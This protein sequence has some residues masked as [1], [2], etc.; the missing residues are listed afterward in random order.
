MAFLVFMSMLYGGDTTSAAE[1]SALVSNQLFN[2]AIRDKPMG[3]NLLSPLS[4]TACFSI[5]YPGAV[6]TTKS[7][8]ASSLRFTGMAS[9]FADFTA[10]AEDWSAKYSGAN[11]TR[12]DPPQPIVAVANSVWVD[13]TLTLKPAYQAVVGNLT[14][15]VDMGAEGTTDTI[16]EWVG[17][18]TRGKISKVLETT[19]GAMLIAVNAVYFKATWQKT[20]EDKYTTLGPFY[21][22]ADRT[23]AVSTSAHLMHQVGHFEFVQTVTHN[24][25]AL[26]YVSGS[27]EM[28]IALPKT[29][30]DTLQTDF[31]KVLSSEMKSTRIALLLPRFMFRADYELK[32]PLTR[33]GMQDAFDP[34]PPGKADFSGISQNTSLFITNVIH[35]TFIAVQEKGTEAAAVTAIMMK[36]TSITRPVDP[37]LFRANRPFSF[38]IRDR[39][40]SAVL[41]V[42]QVAN[43]LPPEDLGTPPVQAGDI[44]K[45]V[46]KVNVVNPEDQMSAAAASAQSSFVA[47]AAVYLTSVCMLV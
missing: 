27:L 47:L 14:R 34:Y 32:G 8:I 12:Y 4:V 17:N 26:P 41:F 28:L 13:Q 30:A 24:I 3:N 5:I 11:T 18:K 45:D 37:I 36:T 39:L 21:S 43:P 16:N 20:F 1:C 7:Q 2:E 10:L 35:K 46:F 29:A 38:A 23:T 22:G 9:P 42:G 15:V 40:S 31:A 6:G 44:W 25:I 19:R 33:M